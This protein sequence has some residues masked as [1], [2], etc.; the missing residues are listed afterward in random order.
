MIVYNNPDGNF[1][2]GFSGDARTARV[3]GKFGQGIRMII[4]G[5]PKMTGRYGFESVS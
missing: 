5:P 2:K 1:E 4:E 3:R